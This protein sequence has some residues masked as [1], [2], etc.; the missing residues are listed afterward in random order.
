MGN[1]SIHEECK[2]PFWC[3]YVY[4]SF[5]YSITSWTFSYKLQVAVFKEFLYAVAGS[6]GYLLRTNTVE[7]Y[8]P[9]NDSWIT[10]ANIMATGNVGISS[11]G[12]RLI[13]AGFF[14]KTDLNKLIIRQ[15]ITL[16]LCILGGKDSQSVLEY[17]EQNDKWLILNDLHVPR[18]GY[19]LEL[20][21]KMK[22]LEFDWLTYE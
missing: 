1:K 6:K 12:N 11:L 22:D 4:D 2:G 7:K 8:D 17:D 19:L 5:F 14:D 9:H 10:L 15:K 20:P 18:A 16:I 3:K 21:K 13:C